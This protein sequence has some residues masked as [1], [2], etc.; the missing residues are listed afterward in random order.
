MTAV[1]LYLAVV[2]I[3]ENSRDMNIALPNYNTGIS[4]SGGEGV[5]VL[6]THPLDPVNVS[7]ENVQ[8]VIA[9]LHRP[10][11]YRI[12]ATVSVSHEDQTRS[13]DVI[14]TVIDGNTLSRRAEADEISYTA[15]EDGMVYIW[16]AADAQNFYSGPAGDL[17]G[18]VTAG[19]PIY[20]DVLSLDP[21]NIRSASFTGDEQGGVIEVETQDTELAYTYY[22]RIRVDTGLLVYAQSRLRGTPVYTMEATAVETPVD[23]FGAYLPYR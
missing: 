17:T 16:S 21:A 6:D 19:I 4:Q 5:Q 14:Y 13:A 2:N 7:A 22:Y 23:G 11:R 15:V 18:D 12:T 10:E 9:T 3:R 8:A 20:E 1:M